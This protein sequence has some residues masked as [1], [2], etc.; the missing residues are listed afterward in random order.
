MD[1]I[2]YLLGMGLILLWNESVSTRVIGGVADLGQSFNDVV[3]TGQFSFVGT[4]LL[5]YVALVRG[6]GD[7]RAPLTC[8]R[9]DCACSS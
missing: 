8:A 6:N 1:L 2:A 7:F 9:S 5:F 4:V 3:Q